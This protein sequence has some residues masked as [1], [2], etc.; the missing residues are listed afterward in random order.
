MSSFDY[1][2]FF[3]DRPAT[4]NGDDLEWED[5]ELHPCLTSL[6]LLFAEMEL[7][8]WYLGEF[9]ERKSCP[10]C[11]TRLSIFD[12]SSEGIA[13]LKTCRNCAYWQSFYD[14]RFSYDPRSSTYSAFISKGREFESK[15]PESCLSEAAQMIR[16]KQQIWNTIEPRKLEGL[17]A[18][19]FRANYSDSEVI[20]VGQ[21]DDG[22]VDVVFIDS[23]NQQW[24]IQVKR[25]ESPFAAEGIST[26]RNLLGAMVLNRALKGIVISTADHFTYRAYEAIGRA[27]EMGMTLKLIDR[28]KL[29]RMLDPLLPDRPWKTALE[30]FLPEEF[31]DFF[32]SCH[33][34]RHPG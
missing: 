21:P 11:S 14:P 13:F 4:I 24:L 15:L 18:E 3:S 12:Y 1:V 33:R 29:N 20:H 9:S 34:Q 32:M 31:L 10:F 25:R 28:G 16:R 6:Q 26:V 30:P 27:R 19:V 22:G 23:A 7:L 8:E 2:S 17:V 5:P